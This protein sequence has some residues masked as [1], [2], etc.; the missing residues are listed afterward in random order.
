MTT[1]RN[2]RSF[3][4]TVNGARYGI[5]IELEGAGFPRDRVQHWTATRD[6]SLG[7]N[8][9]EFVT[10]QAYG[11]QGIN[12]RLTGLDEAF[13]ESG[14]VNES[15]SACSVH[16]HMNVQDLTLTQ[17]ASIITTY[18]ILEDWL[19]EYAAG[20]ERV[21]NLFC[22]RLSDS[23]EPLNVLIEAFESERRFTSTL[24]TDHIRSAALNLNAMARLG[25]LEFRARRGI[26]ESPLE[27]L[28][29][30]QILDR[31]RSWALEIN[32][33]EAIVTLFNRFETPEQFARM[34]IPP[35]FAMP[36]IDPER[37]VD[38]ARRAQW[39]AFLCDFEDVSPEPQ[40]YTS[41]LRNEDLA[42]YIRVASDLPPTTVSW[43]SIYDAVQEATTS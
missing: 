39:L 18:Y 2:L 30:V 7:P 41:S 9:L 31:M 22:L 25:T 10:A 26:D 34:V 4:R 16:V 43:T 13:R 27:V 35:T 8:G 28:E 20:P 6:G 40:G 24:N 1:L 12:R 37:M 29:W 23:E 17:I 32:N 36:E 33:P 19:T 21:G 11:L 5:E 14:F 15:T 38:G 3:D 42:R